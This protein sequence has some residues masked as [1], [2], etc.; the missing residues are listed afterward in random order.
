MKEDSKSIEF[1][2]IFMWNDTREFHRAN[3]ML[4]V[5]SAMEPNDVVFEEL[6]MWDKNGRPLD[7]GTKADPQ[8]WLSLS[9][10]NNPSPII[11]REYL[12]EGLRRFNLAVSAIDKLPLVDVVALVEQQQTSSKGEKV[13][14]RK[15]EKG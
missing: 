2:V 8:Y 4:S 11:L 1:P 5:Q 9:Y 15:R 7:Y 14:S 6:A 3:D 10:S 13:K 12:E